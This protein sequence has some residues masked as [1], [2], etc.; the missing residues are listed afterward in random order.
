MRYLVL[1]VAIVFL[2]V[3]QTLNAQDKYP[4]ELL[5][6][7][8]YFTDIEVQALAEEFQGV[9]ASSGLQDGLFPVR[10][11]G[12]STKPIVDTANTYLSLLSSSELL[13]TQF[14]V[15]SSEWRRW[16]NV[17]NG[18]YVRQGLS[19]KEMS[20]KQRSAA[21][22]I[23]E[24]S[25]SKKGMQQAFDIMKTDRSLSELNSSSFLDEGLYFLTIMGKP[26]ET[27]PWGWQIDGHH[28]V[29]NY[30]V[31]GDQVVVT[32]TFLGAEPAVAKTGKYQG[33]EVLQ[34]E[35]NSG[36][37]FMQSLSQSQQKLALLEAQKQ[38]DNMV[39]AAHK[40]NLILDY[41]GLQAK[42]L[43]PVRKEALLELIHVFVSNIKEG[44]AKVRMDEVRRHIDD[45]WFA[46]AGEA[47]DESV[48]YYRIHSP[49]I[50]IEFD[51]QRP[52][53]TRMLHDQDKPTR[54]HIHVVVR[55][56]NG[57]DYGKDLLK[58]HLSRHKH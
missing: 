55:T 10:M 15:D 16:F 51:H 29:I 54:D 47:K 27:E 37:L 44:H 21:L 1:H 18:V 53:G 17:D 9:H 42:T 45:T 31:L 14:S 24:V 25:L 50:L 46:W 41:S 49:V 5:A 33:N 40:D 36:L 20:A 22:Q 4:N 13:Q 12:V 23:L 6:L 52:I 8:K 57:N 38:S 26:S 3:I 28:L 32:P 34:D 48:F 43:N 35:Q 39:A 2:A 11:T 30:F 56:P 58:Q 7:K 19:L